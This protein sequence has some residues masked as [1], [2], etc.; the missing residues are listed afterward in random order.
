[1]ASISRFIASERIH[2]VNKLAC[3]NAAHPCSCPVAILVS[4][5][6]EDVLHVC[7]QAF[8]KLQNR[9]LPSSPHRLLQLPLQHFRDPLEPDSIRAPISHKCSVPLLRRR[10]PQHVLRDCQQSRHTLHMHTQ[11]TVKM[12]G[13]RKTSP[14]HIDVDYIMQIRFVKL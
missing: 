10:R 2:V 3:E 5:C 11:S 1:M 14:P 6:K 12:R 4:S 9:K 8:S 13:I 7:L